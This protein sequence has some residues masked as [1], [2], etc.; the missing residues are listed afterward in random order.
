LFNFK[1]LSFIFSIILVT[2]GC[3]ETLPL[4]PII[5]EN[6]SSSSHIQQDDTSSEVENPLSSSEQLS[7]GNNSSSSQNGSSSSQSAESS[8][9]QSSNAQ[10]STIQ[11]SSS[12]I[13]P[14]SSAP[15]SSSENEISSSSLLSSSQEQSSS[16]SI[17]MSSSLSVPSYTLY[18]DA[19][20]TSD[21]FATQSAAIGQWP[22]DN[23]SAITWEN[24]EII[25]TTGSSSLKITFNT[26]SG[27]FLNLDDANPAFVDLSSYSQLRFDLRAT[28]NFELKIESGV[29]GNRNWGI[30]SAQDVIGAPLNGQWQSVSIPLD[31][32]TQESIDQGRPLNL[33]AVSVVLGIHNGSGSIHL[34]NIRFE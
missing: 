2:F 12:S 11:S 4:E 33:N 13:P 10:S 29:P 27:I 16:S 22:E 3:R 19:Q 23:A 31:S 5:S 9:A 21:F 7:S 6:S 26:E 28:T 34:D 17:A 30:L 8:T 25:K 18:I 20:E 32:F 14:S 15:L 1:S 24:D